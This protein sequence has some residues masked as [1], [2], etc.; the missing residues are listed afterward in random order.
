MKNRKLFAILTLA[1]FMMTLL[2]VAAFAATDNKGVRV[3]YITDDDDQ[4]LGI[5]R[6]TE[7]E[8][9][10]ISL[11]TGDE[12]IITLPDGAEFS[13]LDAAKTAL[14]GDTAAGHN[15]P[16][17]EKSANLEVSV[18]PNSITKSSFVIEVKDNRKGNATKEWIQVNFDYVYSSSI[19]N[20]Y[21]LRVNIPSGTK[22]N[23]DVEIYSPNG[24]VTNGKVTL[25]Y[26]I[27]GE[28]QATV[29]STE[30]L[31]RGN[32]GQEIGELRIVESNAGALA[33]GDTIKLTLVDE[34]ITWSKDK[35]DEFKTKGYSGWSGIN[36]DKKIDTT[37]S[38]KSQLVITLGG[39]SQRNP[40]VLNISGLKV[41]V[42]DDAELGDLVVKIEG[43]ATKQE[44]V[45]GTIG[46]YGIEVTADDPE[47]VWLG[48]E[49]ETIATFY[50]KETAKGSIVAN[51]RSLELT[52]PEGFAWVAAPEISFEEGGFDDASKAED[53][54]KPSKI[55]DDG[56]TLKYTLDGKFSKKITEI[57]FKDGKITSELNTKYEGDVTVTF[58]G[59]SN[60]E[61]E[62][63][64]AEAKAPVVVEADTTEIVVGKQAQE[65]AEILIKEVEAGAITAKYKG[66][67]LNLKVF[68]DED[69]E[70][71]GTPDVEVID[72]DLKID[73]D[74]VDTDDEVLIIPIKTSSDDKASTIKISNIKYVADRTPAEGNYDIKVGGE[75]INRAYQAYVVEKDPEA[76]KNADVI[77]D[78]E[79]YTF[80][81][82]ADDLDLGAKDGVKFVGI[83]V[84]TP[85][86]GDKTAA[87]EVVFT[88]DEAVYKVDGKEFTMD[89]A[90]Y[91]KDGRTFLPVRFAA[92]A[93]GVDNEN[94][95]WDGGTQTVTIL[96]DA[97]TVQLKL[98]SNVMTINGTPLYMDVTPEMTADRTMLPIRFVAQALGKSVDY[99]EDTKEVIIK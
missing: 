42:D 3:P 86:P 60:I 57:K 34:D 92:V 14:S 10:Y 88:I 46:D 20:P 8:K 83:K 76:A 29:L 68:L 49:E 93:V 15:I 84:V 65:G 30:N 79:G 91:V 89:V 67:D 64:V 11:A 77:T 40:G 55:T 61:G 95:I 85:A 7:D 4:V 52:L 56:R 6:I 37:S 74:K 35:L 17:I 75:A 53:A 72:G 21:S 80:K 26:I 31:N 47:T 25:G 62:V 96:N 28:T 36:F 63:V 5:L 59:T 16:A 97:R 41:D 70:W 38:G 45:L 54:F 22:G 19:T 71:D 27:G 9:E 90:P 23:F 99:K 78:F 94:V 39:K 98:G 48:D 2:P 32:S 73:E 87:R 81:D 24:G 43:D 44:V 82:L 50:V 58:G 69:F 33:S 1:A 13:D 51:G 66:K 18:D 12:I